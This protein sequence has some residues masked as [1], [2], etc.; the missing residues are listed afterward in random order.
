MAATARATRSLLNAQRSSTDPPPLATTKTSTGNRAMRFSA[1]HSDPSALAPCTCAG[2]TISSATGQRRPMTA[3][4]SR[5]AAPSGLV[6]TAMRR[7]KGGR[8]RFLA[9]SRSPSLVSAA[10]A[11]SNASFQS[12]PCS[13]ESSSMM[14]SWNSP[15]SSYIVGR[16]NTNTCIPSVGAG[17]MKFCLANITQRICADLSRRE[18]YQW[19]LRHALKPVISPR[20]HRGGRPASIPSPSRRG[21]EAGLPPLWVRGEITGFKA[22]RSG[23]WY[24]SLRD[25]T[26][27]MRC[28]M[29]AKQNY[30][31]PTPPVDGMQV[32]VFARPSM[33]EEKGEF[34][35]TVMELLS[36]EQ[37]G[38]WKLAFEKAK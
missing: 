29:F 11:F 33:Y 34:Q 38:L 35:L 31:L 8:R 13:V 12:P 20:T 4:M 32:F 18:K 19:P 2:T 36:T 26:A 3:W 9:G 17:S 30:M 7:G 10:F 1:E 21:L 27:Q 37:G 24:F 14:V 16:A 6:T 5:N 15:F 23:H 28:V 25:K 22:W